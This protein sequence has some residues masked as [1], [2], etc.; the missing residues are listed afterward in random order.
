MGKPIVLH[1]G[2]DIQWNHALYQKLNSTFEVKR[3]HSMN[4]EDFKAALQ[5]KQFGDFYAIYRP[6]YSTGGEMGTW[7]AELI[8]LLPA[9]CKIYAACSAGFDWVDVEMLAERGIVYTNAA[10]ACTEPVADAAI[11]CIINTFR[12]FTESALAARS[13]DVDRFRKAQLGIGNYTVNP[14][15]HTLGIIG[16][17][18]IGQRTAQKAHAVFPMKIIYNDIRRL[19]ESIEAETDATFYENVDDLLAIAD[20]IIVATPFGGSKVLDADKI[21]KM[22]HGSRLV[23]IA[24]G[25]LIDEDALVKALESGQVQSAALDVH[26][27]E[28]KV[29]PNLAAMPNVELM[30]HNAGTTLNTQE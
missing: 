26:F 2:G 20:C 12:H 25:K 29:N 5:S 17:G 8:D 10:A 30:S 27:D 9:S 21:S 16:F 3:S 22:K 24:R 19:P 11:Y 18:R 13:L 1:C 7:D 28:P 4:R 15:G 14:R 23:N 6:F